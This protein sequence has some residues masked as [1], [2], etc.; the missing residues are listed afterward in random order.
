[1]AGEP[2]WRWRLPQEGG[3]RAGCQARAPGGD[4]DPGKN[5]PFGA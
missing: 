1:M 5:H 3:F 4:G 2:V